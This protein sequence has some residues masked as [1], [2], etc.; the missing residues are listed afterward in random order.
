MFSILS[1]FTFPLLLVLAVSQLD[2]LV[3][4]LGS[5]YYER[6]K[7][8]RFSLRASRIMKDPGIKTPK[9]D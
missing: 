4:E 8:A 6:C 5:E 9:K 1:E 7:P 3:E 2:P